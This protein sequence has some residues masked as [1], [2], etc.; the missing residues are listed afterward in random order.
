MADGERNY[1]NL[2]ACRVVLCSATAS[3][4]PPVRM[5]EEVLQAAEQPL[6]PLYDFALGTRFGS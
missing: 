6:P 2:A 3:A 4:Q 1:P 5:P